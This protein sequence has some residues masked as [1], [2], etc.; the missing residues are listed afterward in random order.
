MNVVL[1]E[2]DLV[3]CGGDCTQPEN[4]SAKVQSVF[5]PNAAAGSQYFIAKG[6]G[7]VIAAHMS[8]GESFV[9]M[10]RFLR[11]NGHRE[12]VELSVHR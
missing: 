3:F 4:Q 11:T 10:I 7:H 5:Y 12:D 1:G 8:A 2:N 6:S 9:Q